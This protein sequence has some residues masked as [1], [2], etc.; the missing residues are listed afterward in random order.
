MSDLDKLADGLAKY[1]TDPNN[2]DNLLKHPAKR[3][4]IRCGKEYISHHSILAEPNH[5]FCSEECDAKYQEEVK[6]MLAE[7]MPQV[8][9]IVRKVAK[10]KKEGKR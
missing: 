4:C 2:P 3:K 8:Y 6:D 5:G 1:M 10:E 7:A 9:A